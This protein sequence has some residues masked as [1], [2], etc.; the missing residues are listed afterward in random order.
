[1]PSRKY[2]IADAQLEALEK[3]QA[4]IEFAPDGTILNANPNFLSAMGYSLSEIKGRHHRMFVDAAHSNSPE[5][6]QFWSGLRRGEF[7]V[8]EFQRYGKDGREIWIQASYNPIPDEYGSIVKVVKYATDITN[9]KLRNADYAGQIS[10]I[11]KSQAIIEFDMSGII[12]NANDHFLRTTGYMLDEIRGRHHRMFA[13]PDYAASAG[14]EEFWQRLRNGEYA[15]GEYQRFG[16]GGKEVWIQASYNPI[17]D[18]NDKPFKVVKYATDITADKLRNADYAGQ[19]S[20][21]GKSQAVIEFDM[22]GIILNA[23]SNFLQAM[24]YALDEIRGKHHRMFADQ[25][26]ASSTD[27]EQFWQQLRRGE[28]AVGE[29]QRF[30]KGGKEVWIQASYN[31]I[32]DMSNKPFKV[33]K[34]A[35]DITMQMRARIE[36]G[37]V[38]HQ[39]AATTHGVAS[40]AE[41]L[42]ASISEISKNMG[43]SKL[44]VDDIINKTR[45][46]DE[47]MIRLKNTSEYME[48]VVQ[49]IRSIAG[50]VNLLA[51]NATIEAARAGEA[52]RGFAVVAA[53]VKNLA[54]QTGRATDDI[55]TQIN[56]MQNVAAEVAASAL[57]ISNASNSVGEY[58]GSVASAIEE[59]SAVT[60]EISSRMQESSA[61]VTQLNE[62]I[63]RITN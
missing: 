37:H 53:E 57:A 40:A 18:M 6:E 16:K 49:L 62:C 2:A 50:Q 23:N 58:V 35:T 52:G 39:M 48:N 4:M 27:Y 33:V 44:A 46:A 10:A 17:L 3:S 31:P 60:Q 55:A 26:Y 14:Y 25:A 12:L 15:A 47:L 24:G 19:I 61:A 1:M 51:L 63:M 21:I 41:Q 22:N 42:T 11:G 59:Q 56:A 5:Y 7:V 13:D 29:F 54:T 43:Q 30:G 45:Q 38:T 32:M 9:Q 8:C 28:Y 34:Y 36:A 20:A